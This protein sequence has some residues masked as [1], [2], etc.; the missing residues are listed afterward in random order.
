MRR[1]E[2]L[3]LRPLCSALTVVSYRLAIFDFDGTLHDSFPWFL[4]VLG[5]VATKHGLR[6]ITDDEIDVLRGK[7]TRG[8]I[9]H[10]QVPAWKIPLIARD[11]RCLKAEQLDAI[12]LF[13]GVAAMLSALVA[14][15]VVTAIVSSDNESNVRR[16]MGA[17]TARLISLYACGASLFGKAAK[18][19]QVL[20]ASGVPAHEAIKIGDETR[21][22]DAARK[23]GVAFGAV[24][25]GYAAP[26]LLKARA[27][28]AVF[29][30][31]DDIVAAVG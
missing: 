29:E 1:H 28:D 15:G 9:A 4:G 6:C 31:L 26:A 23:A 10:M 17:D 21:D 19:R 11:M 25:W 14:R 13:P 22:H 20:R 5:E 24:T 16:A 8:I 30:S 7:D 2:R 12:P 3:V 18:I 27:P